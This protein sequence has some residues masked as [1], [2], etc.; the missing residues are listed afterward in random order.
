M[1]DRTRR[2]YRKKRAKKSGLPPGSLV[3]VGEPVGPASVARIDYDAAGLREER[4]LDLPGPFETREPATVTWINV[5]NAHQPEVIRRLGEL[6]GLHPLV[7]EDILNH[8]QRPKAEEHGECLFVV[9]KVLDF[10]DERQ[11][12]TG[13][14]LSLVLGPGYLLS[15][16][17]A[18]GSDVLEPVRERLRT[19]RGRL[20]GA[21]PDHLAYALLD[22]VVDH[23]FVALEKLE[24][25]VEALEDGLLSA[26]AAGVLPTILQ[27]KRQTFFVR[28]AVWPLREVIA[29]LQRGDSGLVTEETRIYL[30]DVYD[31][32]VQVMDVAEDL[33]ETVAGMLDLYLSTLNVRLN[34]IIKVL[35]LFTAIFIPLTFVVGVY[36]MNFRHMPEL[37]W[38]WAYPALWAVMLGLGAGMVWYFRR[39]RWL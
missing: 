27:L 15:F 1:S 16:Q 18:H 5:D 33:R 29:Q 2:R 19:N 7:Q 23:Y 14:Q 37:L 32:V 10:N 39:R 35:T 13:E 20:R 12:L 28:H 38:P 3:P 6:F 30:R 9:L 26:P 22:A 31:H 34:E 25:R 11:E 17:E 4:L 21:G 24:D 36:G 8:D